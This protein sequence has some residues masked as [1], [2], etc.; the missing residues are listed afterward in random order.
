M[1]EI[2]Y[3]PQ[4]AGGLL[5]GAASVILML[6]N[7]QIAGISGIA[8]GLLLGPNA[9]ERTWRALFLVGLILGGWA[10]VAFMGDALPPLAFRW[11]ISST[12]LQVGR[13]RGRG[14]R[15]WLHQRPRRLRHRPSVAPIDDRQRDLSRRRRARRHPHQHSFLGANPCLP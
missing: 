6:G 7:G 14:A 15:Q 9:A 5:I 13:R 10:G 8:R 1:S 3:S 2:A 11:P 12:S 4:I